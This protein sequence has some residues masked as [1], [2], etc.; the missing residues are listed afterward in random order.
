MD[1]G[2][3][4]G[5]VTVRFVLWA[6]DGSSTRQRTYH[7]HTEGE[8]V[9]ICKQKNKGFDIAEAWVRNRKLEEVK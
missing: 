4:R 9:H 3:A 1:Q 5:Q 2:A 6:R 8:A 7:G